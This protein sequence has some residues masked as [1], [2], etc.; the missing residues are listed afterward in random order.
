MLYKVE[1]PSC[2]LAYNRLD[3]YR[4][5]YHKPKFL[6][7]S[8]PA[9]GHQLVVYSMIHRVSTC[10]NHPKVGAYKKAMEHHNF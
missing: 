4:S 5:I 3:M 1:P 9:M 8:S 2:K 10:F 7:L 6:E